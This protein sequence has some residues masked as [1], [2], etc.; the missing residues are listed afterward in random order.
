[1]ARTFDMKDIGATK[2]ILGIEIH[3]N[4]RNGKLSFSQ[5]TYVEKILVRFKINKAKPM[6]VHLASDF[7]LSSSLSPNSVKENVVYVSCT[8]YQCSTMFNVG[9]GV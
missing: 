6:N 4:I 3:R 5:E 1:M 7:K 2:Q 9:N 8:I